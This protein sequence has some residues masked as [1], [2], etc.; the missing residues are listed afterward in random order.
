MVSEVKRKEIIEKFADDVTAAA[1]EQRPSLM[2][3]S[4]Y[5]AGDFDN[6]KS[7]IRLIEDMIR[8][9]LPAGYKIG[10]K[11]DDVLVKIMF[12]GTVINL[13]IRNRYEDAKVQFRKKHPIVVREGIS[14]DDLYDRV[15]EA[16]YFAFEGLLEDAMMRENLDL[17]NGAVD[18][19]VKG[20]GL[21]YK[22][23]FVSPF[24]RNTDNKIF[25]LTDQEVVFVADKDRLFKTEDLTILQ[26]PNEFIKQ[27]TIDSAKQIL[28]DKFATA[29]TTAEFVG[30]LGFSLTHFLCDIGKTKKPL[31][32][33]K[34]ITGKNLLN[35]KEV[36]DGQYYYLKDG[37]F[38]IVERKD[39]V[40]EIILTP[41]ST[42]TFQ[43]VEGVDVL[44]SFKK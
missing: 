32:Y 4:Y 21:N 1:D 44:G 26:T 36:Y 27:E 43:R 23:S 24:T 41:F 35:N 3:A 6:V 38:S 13:T 17:I 16:I 20:A 30:N 7:C 11:L 28:M 14:N 37:V 33:L 15:V 8:Y 40:S 5:Q 34:R 10:E 39:G 31:Y 42:E 18:E 22:V 9:R 12:T 25:A 2:I 19:L 29:Q